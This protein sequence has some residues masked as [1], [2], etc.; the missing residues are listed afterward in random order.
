MTFSPWPRRKAHGTHGS[1]VA[2]AVVAAAMLVLGAGAAAAGSGNGPVKPGKEHWKQ[3]GKQVPASPSGAKADVAPEQAEAVELDR[4][5]LAAML[6]PAASQAVIVSLPDPNGGFQRFSVRTSQVMAPGLAEQHPDVATYSGVGVDDP[7]ATIHADLSPLGFHA[8]VRA[9]NGAWYIDPVYHLDQSVY[10]SYYGR[11]VKDDS[12]PFVERDADSA[13]LS[14]DEGYYHSADTVTLRGAGFAADAAVTI[15]ISDPEEHFATRTASATADNT[16]SFE[17]SFVADPE[18][19]LE[20][21][22]VEASDGDSSASASYQVIRDDDPTSDPP[23]GDVLRTYR[24]ALITDPGYATF[25]GG[26][27]NVTAAKVAL[28]NRV[29]QVYEDDLSIHL[30]LIPNNDLL[31]LDTWDKA[32]APNGPCGAAACFTQA[33]VTGCSSTARARFVIGQV[34]GASNYD[35]GHLALGQPGGG[36]ANLGVIGRSNKAGG[37]TGIPTPVGDFYAVDYVA[38]EM[39]HQF[40]GNHP[41]NGN[42]LNCSGG[43]RNPATSVEAGS[44]SSVMAYAGICLTDD[45][46][47][48]SD[49]YF[50]ERS[51]QEISTYTSSNQA[52]INEVQT[53]SLRHFGGGNEVQVVTF[54]PGYAPTA[55]IQ[56]LSLA[57]NAAPGATSRGGAQET[58]NTVT[59][60]TGNPHT[61]QVGDSVTVTGVAAAAYNGTWTV[62][63][64]PSSRSFQYSNPT[65]GLATS[66]GG[67]VTLTAPG[68]T[69]SGTTVT[70]RTALAHGRSV[71]DVVTVSGVGVAAYNGTYT[72]TAVPSPRSFEVT[73]G[74]AG[75]ANSGGGTM[76]FFS[77]F[78]VRVGGNDSAV[79]GGGGLAYTNANIQTAI[80]AIPGFA[81]TTTVSGAASTGFTVSY[82]G[83]SAGLD[84]PSFSLANLSCGGCFASVEETN[85]G[86]AND[87]FRLTYNG[88][89]SASITNGVNYTAAGII[90]A[91]T[92]LLPAGGTVA[93]TG[94]GGGAFNNTGFQMTF[95]G[96]LALTNVPS[97]VGVQDV[98]AGASGFVG[99]TDKG[100]AVD[101]KGIVTPTGDSFPAVTAPTSFTIPL[102]TPFALTGTATD[103]DD[104]ALTYNWEQNDRGGAA[105][106]SLLSNT[107]ANGPLFAMF[108]KSGQISPTD[109]LQYDSPGQN[110]LT[111]SPTRVFPDLQQI[112]DNNTNAATGACPEG[113]IAPPVP[114][115]IT[116][117][118]AEFLPTSDYVG[119]TGI[120]AT[121]L[122]LHFRL[123]ARDGRGGVNSAD[124]TLLLAPTA[125]PFLVNGPAAAAKWVAGSQRTVA[126]SVANTDVA[127]VSTANVRLTL[128]ADGG[129]T[130]PYLL[131]E[132]T[133]NDG[134]Q[135]VTVPKVATS[136][137]RI[138]VEAVGNVFFDI[139]DADFTTVVLPGIV[140]LNG[141]A[142]GG[143]ALTVDS[144]DSSAGAYGPGN[145]GSAATLFSNGPIGLG[146]ADVGGDVVSALSSVDLDRATISGNVTAGTWI[147]GDGTVGGTST[148]NSP[149]APLAAPAV[150]GCSPYSGASGISGKFTYSPATGD[151]TVGG[152]K[153]ATLAAGTYCFHNVVVSGGAMLTVAGPVTIRLKGVLDASGGSLVNQTHVPA[154]LQFESSYHGA[155]GVALSGGTGAY[156]TVYAPSTS[157]TLAGKSPLHGA[158]LGKTLA[159]SGGAA[160]H[161]DVRTLGVWASYFE[162]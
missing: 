18:G 118:Y 132:S 146:H 50:S 76:T 98:T 152:G 108:P 41:F 111:S 157:I 138:R 67:T 27:A 74:T 34:I 150:G 12:A 35:I 24:L 148:A 53:A 40:S 160:I 106:T 25:F 55:A 28:M 38:H 142:F 10:A 159:A 64:V 143:N 16:G 6:A 140:G 32:T 81:G 129:H 63:A 59:I 126:W 66:G 61:L 1:T 123:T 113:P 46:Q 162:N 30:Q 125:G 51:L 68:A 139:S 82:G 133:P 93:V 156:L 19:K 101:N 124:S 20:T 11:N 100:G 56:P 86:G 45:L 87:S 48:H 85:H 39:G 141:V 128:S 154:N 70:F 117:C 17:A 135:S 79:I 145:S 134:S 31:N 60:A 147:A 97:S 33:Q 9:P 104:D 144:F 42:Q 78:Q 83:A 96:T 43:N 72:I 161:Y 57:I 105:G 29:S 23:T 109:A 115:A 89:V 21:H 119:F 22:I 69:E 73:H 158:L 94:F 7:A 137:A 52:A 62:T 54:G 107:K 88:N 15:T 37:C 127:P 3:L 75:L 36:V 136:Q 102:R 155:D 47:A 80:N 114:V 5:G 149:S 121:P 99:E 49:P 120:N 4:A 13:E 151:L 131:A 90:A 8:S 58:G 92:P 153:T 84:V 110:H 71:G 103:A 112:L 77:P 122:S 95:A 44:G 65:G 116:E 26:S 2:L 91:L 130:Y 14:V